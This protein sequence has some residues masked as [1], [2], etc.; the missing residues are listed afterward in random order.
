MRTQAKLNANLKVQRTDLTQYL[1]QTD[2]RDGHA[3]GERA[4]GVRKV[5]IFNLAKNAG[6]SVEQIERFYARHLPLSAEMA[7]NLQEFG[8]QG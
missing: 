1:Q 8:G 2:W 5:N 4:Y 7:R 6:T 3:A